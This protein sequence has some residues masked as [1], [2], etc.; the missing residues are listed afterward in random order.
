MVI[1]IYGRGSGIVSCRCVYLL[2]A[3]EVREE[4]NAGAVRPWI[5]PRQIRGPTGMEKIKASIN[6]VSHSF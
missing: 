2:D 1:W 6:I 4:V 5:L 3:V